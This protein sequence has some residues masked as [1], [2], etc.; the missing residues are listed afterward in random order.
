[1]VLAGSATTFLANISAGASGA[2]LALAAVIP[3]MCVDIFELVQRG[4]HEEALSLQR[5]ITPLAKLLG[6]LHGV[7]ALKYAL[8]RIGYVGG[9]ARPPLGAIPPDAQKKISDELA[10]VK[11]LTGLNADVTLVRVVWVILAFAPP[12]AG[13]L[14]YLIAWLIIPNGEERTTA[15]PEPSVYAR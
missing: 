7:A 3:G 13:V 5:A 6:P 8:D 14:G 2:V 10:R 11:A 12:G 4:R 9:P 1:M 15:A